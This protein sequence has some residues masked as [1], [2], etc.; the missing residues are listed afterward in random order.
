MMQ[1]PPPQK[2]IS[3]KTMM[4]ISQRHHQ[5]YFHSLPSCCNLPAASSIEDDVD[6]TVAPNHSCHLRRERRSH[7]K[8]M[9]AVA[10][11][12]GEGSNLMLLLLLLMMMMM[13]MMLLL[14]SS[15]SLYYYT[16]A[17]VSSSAAACHGSRRMS[18]ASG[19]SF[20]LL[21]CY[22]SVQN[23]DGR[24]WL[25]QDV[26]KRKFVTILAMFP[27]ITAAWKMQGRD[28]TLPRGCIFD[29]QHKT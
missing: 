24:K 1:Q 14:S 3:M 15:W 2:A 9:P 21:C 6:V 12:M 29:S 8:K 10:I 26:P 27:P 25:F 13:M 11:T 18:Q 20:C 22:D 28:T 4:E 7:D 16:V 5:N 23:K 19:T 17:V